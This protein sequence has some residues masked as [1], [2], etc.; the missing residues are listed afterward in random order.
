M[1]SLIAVASCIT[2]LINKDNL[3]YLLIAF[4]LIFLCL[5]VYFV[6]ASIIADDFYGILFAILILTVSATET[7]VALSFLVASEE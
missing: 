3:L 2:I 5:S 4:E 1:A 7:A 6:E